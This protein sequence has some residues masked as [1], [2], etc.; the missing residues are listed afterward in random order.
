MGLKT[1]NNPRR[2]INTSQIVKSVHD[3]DCAK[4]NE[5]KSCRISGEAIDS[6]GAVVEQILD[7]AS[8]RAR[9]NNRVT[10]YPRDLGVLPKTD[11]RFR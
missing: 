7:D 10:I 5:R 3:N 11:A 1:K 2:Y 9:E 4:G 8:K 6:L